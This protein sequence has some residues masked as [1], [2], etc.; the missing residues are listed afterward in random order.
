M[1]EQRYI[2]NRNNWDTA[3][4]ILWLSS[5]VGSRGAGKQSMRCVLFS[6][7]CPGAKEVSLLPSWRLWVLYNSVH[8]GLA[9]HSPV[10]NKWAAVKAKPERGLPPSC[11]HTC[12][13]IRRARPAQH[14]GWLVVRWTPG[15]ASRL[16]CLVCL[17]IQ[18]FLTAVYRSGPQRAGF[19]SFV[20]VSPISK[21]SRTLTRSFLLCINAI[22][23]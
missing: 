15:K 11:H 10:I 21:A 2:F 18:E 22:A 5:G 1:C 4:F 3:P 20:I 23:I 9:S 13:H 19:C 16:Y 8:K 7:E 17:I 14:E 6:I 12:F